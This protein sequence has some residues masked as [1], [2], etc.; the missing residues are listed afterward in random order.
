MFNSEAAVSVDGTRRDP[1]DRDTSGAPTRQLIL[2]TALRLFRE[3]SYATTTMRGIASAAG[4]SVGNAYYYFSG[5]EELVQAFHEGIQDEHR[6]RAAA[7]LAGTADFGERL[8]GVLHAGIDAMAPHHEFAGSF[9]RVAVD[10][11][12]P[13]SPFS[14]QSRAARDGAIGLFAEVVEGATVTLTDDLRTELPRLLWL[15]HM[16]LTLFWV[17]DRSPGQ[18][19]TRALVDGAVPLLVKVLRVTRLPAVRSVVADV[20]RL[21]RTLR[22]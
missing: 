22:S 20:V 3:Q 9:I 19:R 12:S 16:G 11:G 21:A 14:P 4:V 15:A 1:G 13:S 8:R 18:A 10:P 5:K 2:D 7:V 17:H 6:E